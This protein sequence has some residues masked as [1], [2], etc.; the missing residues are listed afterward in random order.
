MSEY[1]LTP[2]EAIRERIRIRERRRNRLF[3]DV[4]IA[5]E[6]VRAPSTP[7]PLAEV[8]ESDTTEAQ[9]ETIVGESSLDGPQTTVADEIFDLSTLNVTQIKQRLT[10]RGVEFPA[11][12]KKAELIE[13][14]KQA[15]D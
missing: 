4:Q 8:I 5:R 6:G 10:A 9:T 11:Y 15:G 3:S 14:L 7:E 12:A 2:E 13:L 1:Y